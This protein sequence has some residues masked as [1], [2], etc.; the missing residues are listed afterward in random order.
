MMQISFGALVES[1]NLFVFGIFGTRTPHK[2]FSVTAVLN[3]AKSGF[4]AGF[5]VEQLRFALG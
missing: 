3:H 5:K 2:P 1:S 4:Q